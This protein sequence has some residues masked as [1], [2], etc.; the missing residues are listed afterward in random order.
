MKIILKSRIESLNNASFSLL[1]PYLKTETEQ[2]LYIFLINALKI[3]C[4]IH[5][6]LCILS[7][8]NN[9]G[10]FFIIEVHAKVTFV[11]DKEMEQC[12]LQSRNNV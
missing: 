8:I 4:A 7:S 2:M 5:K 1:L 11:M 3:V 9:S 6:S 12:E 10:E